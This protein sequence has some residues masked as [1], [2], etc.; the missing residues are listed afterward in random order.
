LKD[1]LGKAKYSSDNLESYSKIFVK[2]IY[3]DFE[4]EPPDPNVYRRLE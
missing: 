1:G 2:A 4:L 3:R